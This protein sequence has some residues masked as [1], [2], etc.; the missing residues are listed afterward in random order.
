VGEADALFDEPSQAEPVRAFLAD[1]RNYL[2]IAYV[3]GVPAGFIAGHALELFLYEAG[4]DEAYRGR[5]I[6]TALVKELARIGREAGCCEMFVLTNESNAP[7]MRMYASA[8]GHWSDE[9][10]IAMFEWTW[11]PAKG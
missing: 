4:V 2:L 8:G 1:P 6:G 3:E 10:D 11:E 5:G 9:R 7:A